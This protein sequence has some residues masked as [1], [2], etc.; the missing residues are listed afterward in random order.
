MLVDY[1]V[2]VFSVYVTIPNCFGVDDY[3]R[4]FFAA[5]EAAALVDS[6]FAGAVLVCGFDSLFG[7]V[8]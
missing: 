3:Y 6:Y 8:A 2:Y 7:V 5:I 4:S 1:F